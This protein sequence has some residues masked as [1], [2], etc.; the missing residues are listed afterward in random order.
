[1]YLMSNED[2]DGEMADVNPA[3]LELAKDPNEWREQRR[4][5]M[6]AKIFGQTQTSTSATDNHAGSIQEYM[7]VERTENFAVVGAS[8]ASDRDQAEANILQQILSH[9]RRRDERTEEAS[10]APAPP[11]V[12]AEAP[13]AG[14]TAQAPQQELSMKEKLMRKYKKQE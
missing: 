12:I 1:M 2:V 5:A 9:K 11:P 6:K 14:P 13:P 3:L 10:A 8:P 7:P 4:R